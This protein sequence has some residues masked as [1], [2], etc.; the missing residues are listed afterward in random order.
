M[1][2]KIRVAG[3]SDIADGKCFEARVGD[4]TLVIVNMDGAFY[5]LDGICTHAGGPMAM[6]WIEDGKIS[7]PLHGAEFDVKTGKRSSM[8]ARADLGVYPVTIEGDDILVDIST[9]GAEAKSP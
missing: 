9:P 4:R 6:G 2:D 8:V 7:C 5:A 3:T 1:P